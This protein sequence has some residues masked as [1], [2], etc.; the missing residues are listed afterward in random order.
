ME[1]N[2]PPSRRQYPDQYD[3]FYP[4]DATQ[5]QPVNPG[6]NPFSP[7]YPRRHATSQVRTWNRKPTR[8]K[9]FKN[10]LRNHGSVLG[11]AFV[12]AAILIT[13]LIF[14]I[15][16]TSSPTSSPTAITAVQQP[17][18]ASEVA[19]ALGCKQFKDLGAAK[20]G[21]AVDM[22]YCYIGSIKYAIDTFASTDARDA[23][24]K[25]SEPFGVNPKW[26]TATSV[27]YKSVT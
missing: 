21:G 2:Y 17:P 16:I 6:P 18:T 4:E 1:S 27:T 22:G 12:L 24:L 7:S 5:N 8:S 3:R 25:V 23:W 13:G 15:K 19:K 26:E 14:A 11:A 20:A 10:Y 9:R